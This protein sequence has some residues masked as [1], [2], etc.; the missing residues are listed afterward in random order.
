MACRR[1]PDRLLGRLDLGPERRSWFPVAQGGTPAVSREL[2]PDRWV[3]VQARVEGCRRAVSVRAL[4]DGDP[5]QEPPD[6]DLELVLQGGMRAQ[7]RREAVSQVGQR[8]EDQVQAQVE[9]CRQAASGLVRV[10]AGRMVAWGRGQ[11]RALVCTQAVAEPG[12]EPVP[13]CKRV[14]LVREP[15]LVRRKA[16]LEEL[17]PVGKR[18]VFEERQ[19]CWVGQQVGVRG[20]VPLASAR[21]PA[22]GRRV[23]DELAPDAQVGE[24]GER[25]VGILVRWGRSSGSGGSVVLL[26]RSPGRVRESNPVHQEGLV[27]GSQPASHIL[28][29]DQCVCIR[30]AGVLS[31]SR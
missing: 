20:L 18:V 7:V 11:E 23:L 28:A 25:Q 9:G 22:Q 15:A 4:R 19:A 13:V 31:C 10:R 6:E 14:V 2:G 21:E 16:E 1:S 24:P 27:E 8:D 26:A 29:G 30:A 12:R 17:V 5:G 3:E